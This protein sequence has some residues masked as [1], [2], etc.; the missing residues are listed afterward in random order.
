[1]E[2]G[3]LIRN[4]HRNLASFIFIVIYCHITRGLLNSSFNLKF[5]W[6]SGWLLITLTIGA[7]FLGYVLP[8]GQIS[9]WGATVITNLIRV[10]PIGR[11]LVI[12][13]W[14]GFYVSNLTCRFFYGLHYLLPLVILIIVV[15]HL[16]FLH[17]RG[18]RT[19]AM[20][21]DNSVS[22]VKFIHYFTLK[23]II[24]CWILYLLWL[25]ILSFPDWASDAENFILAD[26]TNSPIHIQ[27][28]WYFLHLY[29]ILRSIPNKI[30]GLIAFGA[31]LLMPLLFS[32][33]TRHQNLKHFN[34][35][36]VLI[37]SFLVFN[38]ILLWL[39]IQPVEEPFIK[40]GQRLTGCYFVTR[41]V[42]YLF[43]K[44][45]VFLIN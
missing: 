1:V 41:V 14:G 36:L 6:I 10:L 42:I 2:F 15:I 40:I 12:W 11:T 30:G 34:G 28:E 21:C 19:P 44:T 17:F 7:A 4:V 39:G 38:A 33:V 3:W 16:T 31:A 45:F 24:N 5:P 27:P 20:V 32:L 29:A 18:R 26:L 9:F 22:K 35:L 13:L 8:W 37:I 25:V 23:D 43:D